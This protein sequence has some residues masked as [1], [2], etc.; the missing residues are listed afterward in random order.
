[1]LCLCGV[2]EI[3]SKLPARAGRPDRAYARTTNSTRCQQRVTACEQHTGDAPDRSVR[4]F[5]RAGEIGRQFL[6]AGTLGRIRFQHSGTSASSGAGT[7]GT[8]DLIGGGTSPSA[9]SS[10]I[11]F[12][13]SRNA[14]GRPACRR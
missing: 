10:V 11:R 4:R 13:R 14:S 2:L 1:M 7:S 12:S 8:I 6:V 5:R 9:L 3:S